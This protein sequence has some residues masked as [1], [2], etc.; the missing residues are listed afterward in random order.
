MRKED[1]P[2]PAEVSA[3]RSGSGLDAGRVLA[4][5]E[6]AEGRGVGGVARDLVGE[7]PGWG[8][9]ARAGVAGAG[10]AA[11]DVADG[12]EGGGR[13]EAA[14]LQTET[15]GARVPEAVRAE[16]GLGRAHRT[17]STLVKGRSVDGSVTISAAKGTVW[18]ETPT[19]WA[20]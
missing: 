19:I 20:R 11:P 1:T 8:S 10:S 2:E 16:E 13:R 18:P 17:T 6:G 7:L 14:G 5:V 4:S 15:A 12:F 3:P 9:G